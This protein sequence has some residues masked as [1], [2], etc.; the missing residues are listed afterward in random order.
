VN[1]PDRRDARRGF[2]PLSEYHHEPG[3]WA[4]YTTRLALRGLLDAKDFRSSVER[5]VRFAGDA[6]TNG[7]VSGA[8]L[9]TR[10]GASAIK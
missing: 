5:V 7:A 10:F 9:G 3:G 2:A 8:L 1:R 4:V 6:D